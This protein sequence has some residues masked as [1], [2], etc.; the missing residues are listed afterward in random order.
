[1]NFIDEYNQKK[2]TADDAV[3]IIRSGDRK[4]VV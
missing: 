2:V 4:S 1:M 3:K